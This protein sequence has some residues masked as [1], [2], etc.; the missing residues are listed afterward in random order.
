[1][2][3]KKTVIKVAQTAPAMRAPLRLIVGII[4]LL[5][6]VAAWSMVATHSSKANPIV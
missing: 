4:V 3:K 1:M 2:R 5:V 6:G